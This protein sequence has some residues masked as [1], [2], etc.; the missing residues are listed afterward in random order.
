[1]RIAWPAEGADACGRL[2]AAEAAQQGLDQASRK[3]FVGDG[4]TCNWSVWERYFKPQG[5]L[6]IVDFIHL[7]SYVYALAMAVGRTA[8]VGWQM[9]TQ[10]IA[11]LWKGQAANVLAQLANRWR[12][13]SKFRWTSAYGPSQVRWK[14]VLSGRCH[15]SLGRWVFVAGRP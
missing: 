1:M 10:W 4:Q 8:D 11:A 14:K 7:L 15:S 2:L 5:Y 12:R 6:P 3:G 13:S 9:H